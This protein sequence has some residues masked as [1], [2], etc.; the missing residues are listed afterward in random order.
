MKKT[1]I[2]GGTFDPLH[3]GHLLIAEEVLHACSLDEVWFMPSPN[4]PHKRRKVLPANERIE[5]VQRGITGNDRFRLSLFEFNR[6][7]PSYTYDTITALN[8]EYPG[9]DFCFII[10][11]DMVQDLPNWHNIEKLLEMI[12]FVGVKRPGF[13]LESE[14]SHKLT[15]VEVPGFDVSSSFLRGRFAENRNTRYFLPDTVREYIEER[16]LYG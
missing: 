8:Q 16:N 11:A 12:T 9:R 6:E 1:G 5:M 3:F 15:E 4:P 10:G 13:S 14:Y 2:L 7:G